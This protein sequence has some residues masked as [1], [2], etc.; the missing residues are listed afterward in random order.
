MNRG[1]VAEE[2]GDP[3]QTNQGGQFMSG[4]GKGRGQNGRRRKAQM[5]KPVPQSGNV[6]VGVVTASPLRRAWKDQPEAQ[7]ASSRCGSAW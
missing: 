4:G 3:Q 5:L 6:E 7:P 2:M 1:S